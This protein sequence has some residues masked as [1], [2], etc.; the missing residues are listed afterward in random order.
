MQYIWG[1]C[2]WELSSQGV[3]KEPSKYGYRTQKEIQDVKNAR[4]F[5]ALELFFQYGDPGSKISLEVMQKRHLYS[6]AANAF[7]ARWLTSYIWSEEW[8]PSYFRK[9]DTRATLQYANL[10]VKLDSL[11]KKNPLERALVLDALDTLKMPLYNWIMHE[12]CYRR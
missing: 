10:K 9:D 2:N 4:K 12:Y 1:L 3:E 11:Q 7:A 6:K 5:V 8:D